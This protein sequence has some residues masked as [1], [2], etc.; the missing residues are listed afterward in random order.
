MSNL[1]PPGYLCPRIAMNVAKHICKWRH[2]ITMSKGYTI[3]IYISWLLFFFLFSWSPSNFK[4]KKWT[5]T[6][7]FFK[8]THKSNSQH[9]K[10]KWTPTLSTTPNWLRLQLVSLTLGGMDSWWLFCTLALR[11]FVS[12]IAYM[13]LP[14]ISILF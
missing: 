5:L 7:F 9:E 10:R 14:N 8:H 6:F 11:G 1:L 13:S 3:P 2:L 4:Y 12:R